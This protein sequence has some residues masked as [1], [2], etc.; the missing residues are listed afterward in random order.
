MIKLNGFYFK[1]E[2]SFFNVSD[3]VYNL[4]YR[5]RKVS[6]L[7]FINKRENVIVRIKEV[8][9]SIYIKLNFNIEFLNN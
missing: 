9:V 4:S 1:F 8:R 6:E 5:E 2:I 3:F 7:C